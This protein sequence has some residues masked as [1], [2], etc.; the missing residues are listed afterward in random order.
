MTE[1][2]NMEHPDFVVLAG[3]LVTGDEITINPTGHID[4]LLKPLVEGSYRWASIYGN[5]DNGKVLTREDIFKTESKYNLSYTQHGGGGLAGLTNYYLPV[6]AVEGE[7]NQS[8]V[9]ILWFF[10]SRGGF[11]PSGPIPFHIDESVVEWFKHQNQNITKRWGKLPA[12]AYFHIPAAE[13]EEVQGSKE[14]HQP[15]VGPDEENVSP[16]DKNTGLMEALVNSGTIM[17]TFVGHN[18]GNAWCCTYK[19]VEICTIRHTGYGGYGNWTRGA[20]VIELKYP[21]ILQGRK[22][23]IRLENGTVINSFPV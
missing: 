21:N 11:D 7:S 1:I 5:H 20:R 14:N 23:Y 18:H 2:L 15:C 19:G 16:Q 22:N 17:T 3:D 13:Y 9:L 12:L 6:Y 8:P 4:Q 10:D